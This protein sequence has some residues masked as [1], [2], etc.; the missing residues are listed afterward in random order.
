MHFLSISYETA[1]SPKIPQYP[2]VVQWL[3]AV[4]QQAIAWTDIDQVLWYH[5]SS[6]GH[7]VLMGLKESGCYGTFHIHRYAYVLYVK[8]KVLVIFVL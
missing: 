1:L 5:M 3:G 4:T 8:G 2:T 6:S 7:N